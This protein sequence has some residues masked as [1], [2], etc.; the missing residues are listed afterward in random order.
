MLVVVLC[1]RNLEVVIVL[2]RSVKDL[3]RLSLKHPVY[4]SVHENATHSTPTQ[5]EQV[6]LKGGYVFQDFKNLI[7]KLI[8]MLKSAWDGACNLSGMTMYCKQHV[9]LVMS[10]KQ[11]N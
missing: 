4:V 11:V 6:G 9:L 5:L 8:E 3:A 10:P 7:L 2:F 1:F